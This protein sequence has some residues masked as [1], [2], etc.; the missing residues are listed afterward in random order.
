MSGSATAS[1]GRYLLMLAVVISA[2]GAM[3]C[4]SAAVEA[5]GDLDVFELSTSQLYITVA[6][7]SGSTLID[8]ELEVDPVGGSTVFTYFHP[9]LEPGEKRNLPIQ[10]FRGKD[11]T[12]LNLRVHRPKSVSVKAHT[13][14]GDSY[15][16]TGPWQ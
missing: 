7:R 1:P 15:A 2:V 14:G 12:N 9:R 5:T 13:Q 6:N 16:M 10:E 11:G 3:A 8:V 4:S